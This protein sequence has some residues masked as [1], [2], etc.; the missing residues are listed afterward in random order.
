[1]RAEEADRLKFIAGLPAFQAK[2]NRSDNTFLCANIWTWKEISDP[3]NLMIDAEFNWNERL[4][5][6]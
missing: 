3:I 1:M 6:P 2:S 5:C 4:L